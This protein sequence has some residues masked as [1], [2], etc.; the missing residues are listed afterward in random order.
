MWISQENENSGWSQDHQSPPQTGTQE[1]ER[2]RLTLSKKARIRKKGHYVAVQRAGRKFLG[3]KIIVTYRQGRSACPKLGITVSRRYGK[4]HFR[5]RF[6]RVVR[7][8]FRH[9]CGA[10]PRDMELNVTPRLG[11]AQAAPKPNVPRVHPGKIS[12]EAI[13]QDFMQLKEKLSILRPLRSPD[14]DS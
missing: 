12:R 3:E 13:L 2:V 8:A 6:K 11:A 7:E 1:A 4:A 14:H 5:N 10:L 9:Y